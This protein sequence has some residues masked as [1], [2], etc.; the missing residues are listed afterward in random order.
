MNGQALRM[1]YQLSQLRERHRITPPD[2][3]I[4]SFA[5]PT[6]HPLILE[7]LAVTPDVDLDRQRIRPY[8]L[9][10]LA[11]SMPPLLF[12]HD[13]D[14]VAGQ[15]KTLEYRPNGSLFIRALV[16]HPV[17]R[18]CHH[19][20]VGVTVKEFELVD[21]ERPDFYANIKQGWLDEITL[22]DRPAN[23]RAVVT[24]R[25]QSPAAVEQ[26]DLIG[27]HLSTV[28]KMIKLLQQ[29]RA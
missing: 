26:W 14:Q 24:Q 20:S 9:G 29:G 22:T 18:R 25:Y 11:W 12:R 17:A 15:I 7:G 19:W 1:K 27:Q 4:I 2:R 3:H 23:P 28:G 5:P 6:D 10:W 16:D 13:A 21:V 8:A